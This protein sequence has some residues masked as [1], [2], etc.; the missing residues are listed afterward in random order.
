MKNKHNIGSFYCLK[1]RDGM[2]WMEGVA[3]VTNLTVWG[4]KYGNIC[5][6]IPGN[7]NN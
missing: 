2:E 4:A 1:N 3:E 7:L 5:G 6:S